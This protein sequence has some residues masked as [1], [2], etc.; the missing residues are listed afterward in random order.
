MTEA[1]RGTLILAALVAAI[2]ASACTGAR[3][4]IPLRLSNPETL[5]GSWL[6]TIPAERGRCIPGRVSGP[7][8]LTLVLDRPHPDQLAVVNP[9][10]EWL[11]LVHDFRPSVMEPEVFARR[12]T[13]RLPVGETRA[14]V[15]VAGRDTLERVFAAPG[16]YRFVL[17]GRFGTDITQPVYDCS[18]EY[19]EE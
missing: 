14:Y 12:D 4:G 3:E 8:T 11:Y 17:A 6:D 13:L 5:P 10:D 2:L 9:R 16:S 7:D 1:S 19:A 15:A 18:V